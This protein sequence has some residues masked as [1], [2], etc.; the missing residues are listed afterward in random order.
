M[1]FAL[2]FSISIAA[3][4]ALFSIASEGWYWYFTFTLPGAMGK[5]LVWYRIWG[6]LAHYLFTSFAAG[7]LTIVFFLDYSMEKKKR[8]VHRY[9]RFAHSAIGCCDDSNGHSFRAQWH[10]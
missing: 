5:Y 8:M 7:T 4:A 10:L 2:S 9:N 6:G 3:G 1:I